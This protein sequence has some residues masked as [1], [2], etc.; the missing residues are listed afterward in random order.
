MEPWDDP[1]HC[2]TST[3]F[4][5]QKISWPWRDHY[6]CSPYRTCLLLKLCENHSTSWCK[7]DMS[8]YE[9]HSKIWTAFTSFWLPCNTCFPCPLSLRKLAY[10]LNFPL[11]SDLWAVNSTFTV[12]PGSFFSNLPIIC[13][14][15]GNSSPCQLL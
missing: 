5:L 11:S 9:L 3:I 15:N 10:L 6:C 13:I 8:L 14:A 2:E 7:S 1:N 4:L 12:A